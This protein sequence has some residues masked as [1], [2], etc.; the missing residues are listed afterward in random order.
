[1]FVVKN[2]SFTNIICLFFS[3]E[4]LRASTYWLFMVVL[5]CVSLCFSFYHSSSLPCFCLLL[6]LIGWFT[7]TW[8]NQSWHCFMLI[9]SSVTTLFQFQPIRLLQLTIYFFVCQQFDSLCWLTLS[10]VFV[11]V[12]SLDWTCVYIPILLSIVV[13]YSPSYPLFTLCC[14][15]GL[16]TVCSYLCNHSFPFLMFPYRGLV[17]RLVGK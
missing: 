17:E 8:C 3:G 6:F 14:Y 4:V 9:G 7:S 11:L 2:I 1:M 15:F 5:L 16:V 10:L 13:I 12:C